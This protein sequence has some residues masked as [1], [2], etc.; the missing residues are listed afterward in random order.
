MALCPPKLSTSRAVHT[1]SPAESIGIGMESL[2]LVPGPNTGP[3]AD[4]GAG[5]PLAS[6]C[7]SHF[8]SVTWPT[9]TP[10]ILS[11]LSSSQLT[12][13]STVF[14]PRP[15]TPSTP[16]HA[17]RPNCWMPFHTVSNAVLTLFHWFAQ[18][19]RNDS[20]P[21]RKNP[22]TALQMFCPVSRIPRQMLPKKLLMLF[23]RSRQNWTKRPICVRRKRDIAFQRFW[24]VARIRLQVFAK[25][26]RMRFHMF[27]QNAQYA[28]SAERN[29]RTMA[30][31]T[32]WMVERMPFQ[33]LVK[34]V[35]I[36]FQM[37]CQNDTNAFS[38][39]VNHDTMAFQMLL[40]TWRIWP[41]RFDVMSLIAPKSPRNSALMTPN[42]AAKYVLIAF[43]IGWM[44]LFQMKLNTL[45][46]M[47]RIPLNTVE[48]MLPS[49]DMIGARNDWMAPNVVLNALPI[50]PRNP[51][52]ALRAPPNTVE[53][54]L[55]NQDRIGPTTVC[56][57]PNVVW[58]ARPSGA[59]TLL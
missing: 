49:Q 4:P 46:T 27:C 14:T 12:P 58:K 39:D 9:L 57:T 53:M 28:L 13:R 54:M 44:M 29:Q 55:P 20:M 30:F 26:L 33:M 5:P 48:K 19:W 22:D 6:L 43:Q 51:P 21:R 16:F 18:V 56:S 59:S 17:D 25:K 2:V 1:C 10:G 23:Q 37:F 7:C 52:A 35:L 32:F 47:L 38:A 31:H 34:N 8:H 36:R 42:T 40:M 11:I 50:Q 24:T 41:I 3:A 15:M 45:E